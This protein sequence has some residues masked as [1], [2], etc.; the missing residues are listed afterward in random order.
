M[1]GGL[2]GAKA[3]AV[4]GAI[5]GPL[6]VAIGGA[7]GGIAGGL[8]GAWGGKSAGEAMAGSKSIPKMAEGGVVTQ[9]TTVLAGEAGPEA[10]IPLKHFESLQ[11]EL[12]MLNKQ[13]AEM[14]RYMRDTAEYTKRTV[15][16]TKSLNGDLF[17]F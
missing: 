1:A 11:I 8:L 14:I 3:G 4:I 17:K 16:A 7:I 12:Q 15:D 5:G 13:T 10:I 6:G 9:P 2:A